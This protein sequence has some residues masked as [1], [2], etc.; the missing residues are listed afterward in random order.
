[1]RFRHTTWGFGI[2]YTAFSLAVEIFLLVV[3]RLRIPQDNKIIA[4]IILVVAPLLAAWVCGYRKRSAIVVVA[5]LALVLT[6]L[7][8]MV[9]GRLAGI[10]TGLGPPILIRSLA[11][12]FAALATQRLIRNGTGSERYK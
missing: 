9:F 3:I 8:T 12:F 2:I 11:G 5:V 6:L 10:S 1:M 7:F 4:P